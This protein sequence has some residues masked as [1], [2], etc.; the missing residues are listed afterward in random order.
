ML[1]KSR[2][3]F[4]AI[5]MSASCMSF[6]EA[7]KVQ[8]VIPYA[9]SAKIP[10]KIRTECT[11]LGSQLAQFTQE[12]GKSFG[13]RIELT[14]KLDI[15]EQGRVLHLEF[16]DAISKGNAFIGHQ[17]S[18]AAHG[19][20]YQDGKK[21]AEFDVS[22]DSMGG[23]FAGYKGSCSVLGRTVKTMGK[24]IAQWLKDP[25]DKAELGDF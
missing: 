23:M 7:I 13:V 15:N 10:Q 18:T 5:A 20:L 22:R 2:I 14:D 24:D 1:K 19:I 6:A 17:K 25:K 3:A 8:S 11:K 4:L 16:T 9:E 12:F 21:I